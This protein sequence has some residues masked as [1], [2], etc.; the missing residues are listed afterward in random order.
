[1]ET[2]PPGGRR[3]PHCESGRLRHRN[4]E[5]ATKAARIRAPM[6][7]GPGLPPF[8]LWRSAGTAFS[9]WALRSVWLAEVE[10]VE[11]G[12]AEP[13]ATT[14]VDVVDGATDDAVPPLEVT[15]VGCVALADAE[16][17]TFA[18]TTV[19]TGTVLVVGVMVVAV[20][21]VTGSVGP[22]TVA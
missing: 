5:A 10:G 6:M 12:D 22:H 15:A 11:L 1:M 18:G 20:V 2:S 3:P 16:P 9:A 21:V 13:E 4:T 14:V 19:V 17:F 8:S 7:N